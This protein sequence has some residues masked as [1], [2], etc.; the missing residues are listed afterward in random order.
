MDV[1]DIVAAPF[2]WGSALR[3]KRFFHP[4][5]VLAE[6]FVERVVLTRAVALRPV[7]SWGGQTLTT[8]MS[9][10]YQGCNWWLR[11]RIVTDIDG[12]RVSLDDIRNI[13]GQGGIEVALDQACG[14]GDFTPLGRLRIACR[15]GDATPGRAAVGGT[16]ARPRRASA[17]SPADWRTR[18]RGRPAP[19]SNSRGPNDGT[20]TTAGRC[21]TRARVGV[22]S[23]LRTGCGATAFTGPRQG[24]V[25]QRAVIDVDQVVDPDPGQPLPAVAEPAAQA[26]AEQRTHQLQRA[27]S[28]RLHDAG[29]YL[30]DPHPR[31]L[32]GRGRLLPFGD[33]VGQE[34]VA[35]IA[36]LG[37]GLVAAVVAVE[38]DRR[39][40]D[41]GGGPDRSLPGP[42]V[43]PAGG[44]A[45]SCCRGSPADARR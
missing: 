44:S 31:P 5:G 9:L 45:R 29:A 41:Q 42:A 14:R 7:T 1:P 19:P 2:G 36:V 22:Y 25:P 6:G 34:P 21:K 4:L 16:G 39:G 8:L 24:G 33:D 20:G 26:R 18:A 30:H 23:L 12:V 17:V 40:G 3:G 37:E 27:A 28:R 35:A 43:R 11:G 38:A 13:I 15:A 10:H 32:R